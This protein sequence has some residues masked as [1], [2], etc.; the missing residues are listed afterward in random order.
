[1]TEKGEKGRSA[2]RHAFKDIY[3]PVMV[4]AVRAALQKCNLDAGDIAYVDM[5]NNNLK[6]QQALL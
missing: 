1:M 4:E 5:V 2:S 6:A 3:V